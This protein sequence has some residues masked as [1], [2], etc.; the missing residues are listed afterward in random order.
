M[1]STKSL[2]RL[3]FN[4]IFSFRF[5]KPLWQNKFSPGICF[6]ILFFCFPKFSAAQLS[7][8]MQA[9]YQNQHSFF[10]TDTIIS[11]TTHH[12]RKKLTAPQKAAL[13]SACLPGLGQAYNHKW[14]K[15]P[16]IYAGMGGL[17]YSFWWNNSFVKDYKTALRIRYDGDS[18]THDAYE[19][20]Y[21]DNDLVTLKNYYQRYR[22]LSVIGMAALYT[23][24]IVDACVDAHLATFD[25]SDDLS[26]NICPHV[27]AT[28][29]GMMASFGVRLYYR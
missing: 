20:R 3:I 5:L 27:Y 6:A 15:I 24:Q 28:Q 17:G 7:F 9:A 18:S 14:W 13:M 23:L 29:Q 8:G 16:I 26:L 12:F 1:N 21:S 11:D 4:R 10:S 22:D 19:N 25:V 2:T